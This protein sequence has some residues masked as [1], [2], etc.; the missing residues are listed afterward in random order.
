MSDIPG[1]NISQEEPDTNI[2]AITQYDVRQLFPA[3]REK[4]ILPQTPIRAHLSYSSD[5]RTPPDSSP[6]LADEFW[7]HWHAPQ[8]VASPCAATTE[9]QKCHLAPD[10][11]P[12]LRPLLDSNELYERGSYSNKEL[13]VWTAE[14]DRRGVHAAN[15]RVEVLTSTLQRLRLSPDSQQHKNICNESPIQGPRFQR[16]ENPEPRSPFSEHA[17][18]ISHDQSLPLEPDY[19]NYED[20]WSSSPLTDPHDRPIYAIAAHEREFAIVDLIK[21][22]TRSPRYLS[23]CKDETA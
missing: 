10:L 5:S 12:Q 13:R 2:T 11:K 14:Y 19:P 16:P 17:E 18:R 21:V 22:S 23:G 9:K 7:A 6:N 3:Q 1:I 20:I 4:P 15:D 8:H